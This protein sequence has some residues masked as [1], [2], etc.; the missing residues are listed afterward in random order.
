MHAVV[1]ASGAGKTSLFRLI[2]GLD[3]SP[4]LTTHWEGKTIDTIPTHLR[5][6]A[7]VPQRP[8]LIPHRTIAQ[9]VEWVAADQCGSWTQWID[10]LGLRLHWLRY[11]GELSG[12]EQQRAALLR[13]LAADRAILLLDEALS[14]IDPPHRLTIYRQLKSMLAP[15]RI[16]LFSTH[17]WNE[18][19]T[20]AEA[21]LFIDHGE[22]SGPMKMLD[23]APV[24]SEMAA[25]MGYIGSIPT[26]QGFLL[27]HPRMIS[28]DTLS[29]EEFVIPGKGRQQRISPTAAA[30][31]FEPSGSDAGCLIWTGTPSPGKEDF[32][33]ITVCRPIFASFPFESIENN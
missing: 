8:S 30:Y 20:F 19:E 22:I 14:Q 23:V 28:L 11:P 5:S 18:A 9:Q 4:K 12:G 27:I 13:A 7:Y 3:R 1:G 2:A 21:A 17:H 6:T 16:L 24:N 29:E 25:I 10:I 32:D 33:S 26:T 31:R 15:G